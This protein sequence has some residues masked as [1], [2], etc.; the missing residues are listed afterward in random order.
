[1]FVACDESGV[2]G[3][4]FVLGSVW[5]PKENVSEF[6][7]RVSELRL[8]FKCWGEVKWEKISDHTSENVM[9]FYREFIE[10]ISDMDTFFRFIVVDTKKLDKGRVDE[11]L[12]L[13]F[14]YLLISRNA[15]RRVLRKRINPNDLHIIFDQFKESRQSRDEG[16]RMETRD[17]LNKY[18]HCKIEH[19]QPCSSHINSL[20]QLIDV[21]TSM[22]SE[23]INS[24]EKS[25]SSKNREQ[26]A[27]LVEKYR[28]K[29]GERFAVW[30]WEPHQ[31]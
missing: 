11:K 31:K 24:S 26:I 3:R 20:L 2:G 12:Q 19:L 5:V 14:M 29:Y 22:L 4:Y 27:R 7:K 6:E 16:W 28:E 23:K 17:F 1:M 8:R 21:F 10:A 30:D 25:F 18:L 13:Q 9:C 15:V